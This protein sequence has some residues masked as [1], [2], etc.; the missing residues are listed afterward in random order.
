MDSAAETRTCCQVVENQVVGEGS[1]DI[2]QE[3]PAA[4]DRCIPGCGLLL[5]CGGLLI[6]RQRNIKIWGVHRLG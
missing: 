6:L 4:F 2:E 5:I 3:N 1:L